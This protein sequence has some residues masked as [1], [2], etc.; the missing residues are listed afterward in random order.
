[1]YFRV[2]EDYEKVFGSDHT[3]TFITINN[4]GILYKNQG[5]LA[6]AE[7]MYHR[8]LEGSEK[9]LGSDYTSTLK[10]IGNLGNLYSNQGK[11]AK[12][13]IMY[14]RVLEGYEKAFGPDHIS[15]LIIVG[16]LGLLY[17]NQGNLAETKIMYLQVLEG[18]EKAFGFELALFYLLVL[19]II[20]AF[21]NLFSQ[22]D[23]K[24]MAREMYIRALSGYTTVQGPFSKLIG[25][26]RQNENTMSKI[27]N[28]RSLKRKSAS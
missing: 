9:A 19:Y 18:Y 8:A 17:L 23:R 4:L 16:N 15:I 12:A 10:I 27:A 26:K 6:E 2:L 11:L 7:K 1:M 5:K 24:D 25:S 21:G 14:L 13:E 28:L 22:T 20:S 3:S